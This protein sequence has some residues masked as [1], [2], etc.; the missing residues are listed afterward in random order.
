MNKYACYIKKTALLPG[1]S[2]LLKIGSILW[3]FIVFTGFACQAKNIAKSGVIDLRNYQW[4]ADGIT[5][6][7]GE[8]A[9]Y[10]GHLYTAASIDSAKIKAVVYAKVPGFWNSLI[11]GIGLIRP[12]FGYAT[13]RLK[14][15][16]PSSNEKLDLKF[17]TVSSA[18]K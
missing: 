17:L 8:W 11:P 18:Y 4:S 14:V 5:D 3:L 2:T 12:A 7:N 6:L 16:C 13:Y 10:W 1:L 9:F 15:L